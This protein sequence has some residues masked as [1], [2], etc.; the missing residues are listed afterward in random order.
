MKTILVGNGLNQ[1]LGGS[2]YSN[3]SIIER[4]HKNVTAKNYSKEFAN[5][6]TSEDLRSVTEGLEGEIFQDT[7]AGKYDNSCKSKDE[8]DNLN[9]VKDNYDIS[10]TYI[11]MED[12]FLLLRLYHR[13]YND[14]AEMIRDTAFGLSYLFL[15]AIFNEGKIQNLYNELLP[16]RAEELKKVF[17]GF[18]EIYTVNYDWNIEKIAG[19]EVGHM[20]GQFDR[21][22]TQFIPETKMGDYR[23]NILY[24][25][26]PVDD[27]NRHMYCNAIMGFC[28]AEKERIMK[29]FNSFESDEY[30]TQRF[31]AITGTI[32]LAGISPN[33]DEH[34]WQLIRGNSNI[35]EIIFYYHSDKD[36]SIAERYIVDPR[37][38][39]ENVDNLW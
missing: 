14:S 29:I 4:V 26:N 6:V 3:A 16:D 5:K 34:I 19:K 36:R 12:Y 13:Y 20:H 24:L 38:R 23:E 17:A 35:S 10:D 11:G 22:N 21:L 25:K 18:D 37:V 7:L 30:P 32:C 27:T 15:D 28:G 2:D 9:R 1:A 33:N 8:I 39:Y 31:K